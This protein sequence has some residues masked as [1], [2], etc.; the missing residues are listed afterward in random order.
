MPI[1]ALAILKDQLS[2]T[3]VKRIVE[4]KLVDFDMVV[5]SVPAGMPT[6]SFSLAVTQP[7][8]KVGR[9]EGM[10][11]TLWNALYGKDQRGIMSVLVGSDDVSKVAA[12]LDGLER[13]VASGGF[14]ERLFLYELSYNSLRGGQLKKIALPDLPELITMSTPSSFG[15]DICEGEIGKEDIKSIPWRQITIKPFAGD[16]TKAVISAV[17]RVRPEEKGILRNVV[18]DVESLWSY[19]A[20]ATNP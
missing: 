5:P 1:N 14:A 16:P 17:Y 15:V 4:G 20:E 8:L 12:A 6:F 7:G 3:D 13:F 19:V 18:V 2:P 11:L 9:L 10:D